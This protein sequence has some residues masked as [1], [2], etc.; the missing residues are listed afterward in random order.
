M[1][2]A[3]KYLPVEGSIMLTPSCDAA[4]L[5]IYENPSG[6]AILSK[7]ISAP[8]RIGDTGGAPLES[9]PESEQCPPGER[10]ITPQ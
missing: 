2:E 1:Q 8:P 7:V 4:T 3:V 5:H 6:D 9:E 10:N